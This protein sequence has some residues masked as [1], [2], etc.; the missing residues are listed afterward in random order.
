MWWPLLLTTGS[1]EVPVLGVVTRYSDPAWVA[2]GNSIYPNFTNLD[3]DTFT[4]F[5]WDA[6]LNVTPVQVDPAVC[7]GQLADGT[8][9]VYAPHQHEDKF[10]EAYSRYGFSVRRSS[11]QLSSPYE[12][13]HFDVTAEHD[14]GVN[15]TWFELAVGTGHFV[16]AA[17]LICRS[18]H[19]CRFPNGD[20]AAGYDTN[21]N[22]T[23]VIGE[24]GRELPVPSVLFTTEDLGLRWL[25][26]RGTMLLRQT[27]VV[28]GSVAPVFRGEAC[29]N[30]PVVLCRPPMGTPRLDGP[31]CESVSEKEPD[32]LLVAAAVLL[33]WL[34][35]ARFEA[36]KPDIESLRDLLTGFMIWWPAN[37]IGDGMPLF[38]A[39]G[40]NVAVTMLAMTLGG[41]AV[42]LPWPETPA[43]LRGF[44]LLGC[45]SLALSFLNMP[46]AAFAAG[47]AGSGATAIVWGITR[48]AKSVGIGMTLSAVISSVAVLVCQTSA[49]YVIFSIAVAG[50]GLYFRSQKQPRPNEG[51]ELPEAEEAF[52]DSH[53]DK[54]APDLET[55]VAE[56]SEEAPKLP[57]KF[58]DNGVYF[59]FYAL[60]YALPG[61]L[62]ELA[63]ST[64]QYKW[65]IA[66]GTAGDILG[67]LFSGN[68]SP[69]HL[70]CCILA[71]V[72]LI[73]SE[74]YL[75]RALLVVGFYTIRGDA[76]VLLA[77]RAGKG[78]KIGIFGQL[79]GTA[80][81][82]ATALL[83]SK[84]GRSR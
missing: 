22:G 2:Y 23:V 7:E 82:L 60:A 63:L 57:S 48:N 27:L 9:Y 55:P 65:I 44:A 53:E 8:A 38:A 59:V 51:A 50:A 43:A 30:K 78:T 75:S 12:V 47:F 13:R 37:V 70:P 72:A 20:M 46:V 33:V 36:S 67:R 77:S 35:H 18:F 69:A 74:Q 79:G 83:V 81:A 34:A 68:S 14:R 45:T 52:I 21:L 61:V 10:N 16:E 3:L 42:L 64:P 49:G 54:L 73:T 41:V 71:F 40:T 66:L 25:K 6:P 58:K 11:T 84:T 1:A 17:P 24:F 32:A 19:T 39:Q 56:T 5:Y 28:N 31:G 29:E 62:P 80:G 76:V 15:S 4:W 26:Y